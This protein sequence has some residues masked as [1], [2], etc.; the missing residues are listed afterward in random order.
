MNHGGGGARRLVVDQAT[1]RIGI[2]ARM[3]RPVDGRSRFARAASVLGAMSEQCSEYTS[4]QMAISR[5][6]PGVFPIAMSVCWKDCS[7]VG[8]ISGL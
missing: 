7:A 3:Q 8:A 6:V 2:E 4:R 5:R 1:L